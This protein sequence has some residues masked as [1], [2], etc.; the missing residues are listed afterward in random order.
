MS[1]LPGISVRPS[2]YVSFLSHASLEAC[3]C[4]TPENMGTVPTLPGCLADR[5]CL[6]YQLAHLFQSFPLSFTTHLPPAPAPG[7]SLR[8]STRTA[9]PCP[10]PTGCTAFALGPRGEAEIRF[11]GGPLAGGGGEEGQGSLCW[12]IYSKRCRTHSP[13]LSKVISQFNKLLSYHFL[14]HEEML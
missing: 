6:Q 4:A 9:L 10:S 8:P 1:P 5:M 14:R 12:R 3:C 11:S 7:I 2:H 13:S